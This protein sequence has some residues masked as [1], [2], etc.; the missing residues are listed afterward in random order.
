MSSRAVGRPGL[1][2]QFGEI[3]RPTA[4]RRNEICE[5]SIGVVC[6][7]LYGNRQAYTPNQFE[8]ET[9]PGFMAY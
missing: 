6:A 8:F 1:I 3:S 5:P 9:G 7:K 2:D 4:T